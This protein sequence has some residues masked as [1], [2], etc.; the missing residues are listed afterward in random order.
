VAPEEA[1]SGIIFIPR[2]SGINISIYLEDVK[3]GLPISDIYI[4]S[5]NATL[6]G[7]DFI[8]VYNG[9]PGYYECII[10]SNGPT[11]LD[12]GSTYNVR[13]TA[14][15]SN[16]I[17]ASGIFKISL[18]QT[19]STLD[20][21]GET[22]DEMVRVYSQLVNFTVHLY[23]PDLLEDINNASVVWVLSEKGLFGNLTWMGYGGLYYVTFNTTEVGFGIWGISFRA[24]PD[25]PIYSNSAARLSLTINRIP[26]DVIREFTEIV[27]EWGWNGN[28]SFIFNTTLFGPIA[29][30]IA[31]YT[32]DGG[33]GNATDIGNGTYIIP[34]DTMLVDPGTYT[35]T[36]VFQKENYQEGP[37]SVRI[38]VNEVETELSVAYVE[39]NPIYYGTINDPYNLQIPI[40]DSVTIYFWYNDTNPQDG[41][42]GGLAGAQSTLN[43]Y[44]RGPSIEGYLNIS[45]HDE[46]GGLYS[47]TFST[48]DSALAAFVDDELYRI[49]F[50]MSLVNRKTTDSDPIRIKIIKIPTEL[51]LIGSDAD[52]TTPISFTNG[53]N[54]TFVYFFN[55]TW[56]NQGIVGQKLNI[57]APELE[58]I[59]T[60][61]VNDLGTGSYEVTFLTGALLATGSG[62]VEI[63]IGL[64]DYD[65]KS[66]QVILAVSSN[67]RDI[68]TR[69]IIQI[70]LPIAIIVILLLTGYVRIWSVPKRLRQINGQIKAIRKGK[71]PKALPV[72]MR[73]ELISDLFN[74]TYSDTGITRKPSQMPEE[75]IPVEIPEMGELLIQLAILTNLSP[76]ELDEFKADIAKM[77]LSEQSAFVREVIEQEAIRAARRDGKTVNQVLK[78]VEEEASRRIA[79]DEMVPAVSVPAEPEVESVILKDEIVPTLEPTE[80]PE[81]SEPT[82]TEPSIDMDDKLS[83]FELEE[84]RAD[85]IR[86]GVPEHEINILIE[87]AKTLPRDLVDELVK[88][89]D[90]GE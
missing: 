31:G 50:E 70:G 30:A 59:V 69:S 38:I 13:L 66:Y 3:N 51:I 84:L 41:Y 49:Y 12:I 16:Y 7:L 2:G 67:Q 17:P 55:D 44:L 29:D 10:P 36:L 25:D 33:S 9:T 63:E 90:K 56:H 75:T 89:L 81:P 62:I 43:S 73:Q 53:D 76:G 26:T 35:L 64:G 14:S 45:L 79:G 57:S 24:T 18:L 60:F 42:V 47:Y 22:T 28:I 68:L 88:S 20:L 48:T 19:Q 39:Y 61:V 11:I 8:F 4:Q 21:T 77:K 54:P 32:W 87:Q 74:D 65:Y 58:G 78:E 86:K 34:I 83:S 23:A 72:K 37:T 80:A 1:I 71:I 27:R 82:I 5:V 46:G 6:E 15:L 85:L 52:V 40:G